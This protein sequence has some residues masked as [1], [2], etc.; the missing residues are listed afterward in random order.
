MPE[1]REVWVAEADGAILG[2]AVLD[3]EWLDSLYVRPELTGRG[4][5]SALLDLVKSLRPGERG[6]GGDGATIVRL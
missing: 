1:E 6:E 5:G 3:P 2:Y 4:I